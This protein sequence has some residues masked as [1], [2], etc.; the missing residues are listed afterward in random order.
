VEVRE[1]VSPAAKAL[2]T[3]RKSFL[4]QGTLFYVVWY[5][6]VVSVGGGR[7]IDATILAG[8][9]ALL[10]LLQS[11]FPLARTVVAALFAAIGD[12]IVTYAL[13]IARYP[14]DE[15]SLFDYPAWLGLMWVIFAGCLGGC[16]S[17]LVRIP[18]AFAAVIGA[19]GGALSSYAASAFG[20]VGYPR[21][22]IIGLM[23]TGA[24]WAVALPSIIL[25]L[26]QSSTGHRKKI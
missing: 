6:V 17:V 25:F 19:L 3:K 26:T 13:E 7:I 24:L 22:V 21:G 12:L 11:E 9:F 20:A 10:T 2:S 1:I 16:L 15:V 4:L 18:P 23:A 8:A 5:L 14:H